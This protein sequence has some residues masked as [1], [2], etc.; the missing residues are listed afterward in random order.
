MAF[1]FLLFGLA[2][3]LSVCLRWGRDEDMEDHIDPLLNPLTRARMQQGMVN[4][5]L[6]RSALASL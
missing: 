5:I 3:A 4:V 2:A 1:G 6:S